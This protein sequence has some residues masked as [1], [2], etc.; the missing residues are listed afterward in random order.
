MAD[1]FRRQIEQSPDIAL[2]NRNNPAFVTDIRFYPQSKFDEQ[3]NLWYQ[4]EL[5]DEVPEEFSE[6]INRYNRA[7]A[8][9]VLSEAELAGTPVI[10]YTDSYK[11]TRKKRALVGIKS[12]PMSPF[13]EKVD[14]DA[15]IAQLYRAKKVVDEQGLI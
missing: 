6:M 14:M 8:E 11:T 15:V 4:R 13:T 10:S 2:L 3:G 12:Y 7:I 5:H 1:Y 9:F